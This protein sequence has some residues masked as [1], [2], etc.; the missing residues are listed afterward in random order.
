MM[1][2]LDGNDVTTV[3]EIVVEGCPN[4]FYPWHMAITYYNDLRYDQRER[5]LKGIFLLKGLKKDSF[6]LYFGESE[7]IGNKFTLS[8]EIEY[9]EE[10]NKIIKIPYKSCFIP[11][12]NRIVFSFRDKEEKYRLVVL[13]I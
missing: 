11:N 9:S 5:R 13:D 12:E 10:I 7:G 3:K 1:K 6:K 8:K 2:Q 4:G